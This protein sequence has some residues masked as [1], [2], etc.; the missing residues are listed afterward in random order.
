MRISQALLLA[1]LLITLAVHSVRADFIISTDSDYGGYARRIARDGSQKVS[2][3]LDGLV[4]DFETMGTTHAATPDGTIVY[5]FTN[6][7]GHSNHIF[8]FNAKTGAHLPAATLHSGFLSPADP[9]DQIIQARQAL[10]RPVDPLAVG[11]LFVISD[12][13]EIKRYKRSTNSY[14]ETIS[15]PTSQAVY[16]F[17]FGPNNWLHM[18]GADGIIPYREF[19]TGLSTA[20]FEI[21]NPIFP[22]ITLATGSIAFGPDGLLYLRD[23]ASGNVDRY[24]VTGVPLGT[25]IPASAIADP[26][27]VDPLLMAGRGSIQF[28]PDGHLYL[29]QHGNN[30]IGR[31]SGATGELKSTTPY[32]TA[33]GQAAYGR[34]TVFPVPEPATAMLLV[35][36]CGVAIA[37][38]NRGVTILSHV[39]KQPTI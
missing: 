9:E 17:A 38:R 36:A 32:S 25:F 27:S 1:I 4:H 24:T 3:E 2:Y 14:V 12:H 33:S 23:L 19:I 28:G 7:L 11:D 22:T 13:S 35:S 15:P 20:E 18:A 6:T 29:F 8:A 39:S 16:D 37:R 21:A 31:F 34:I 26:A 5:V 10:I 30:T